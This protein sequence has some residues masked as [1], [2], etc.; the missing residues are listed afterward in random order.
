[1]CWVFIAACRLSLV[2]ESGSYSLG[3]VLR[4]LTAVAPLV[5]EHRL[6]G[7]ELQ[8]LWCIGLAARRQGESSWTRD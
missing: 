5:V 6:Q 8:K 4:L 7:H 1:L 2:A 3:A